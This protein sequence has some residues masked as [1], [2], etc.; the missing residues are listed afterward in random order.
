MKGGAY[1]K[2]VVDPASELEHARLIVEREE[3]HVHRTRGPELG[4]WRPKN[5]HY[6]LQ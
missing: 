2:S 6:L 4:W 5:Y 1:R 3:G